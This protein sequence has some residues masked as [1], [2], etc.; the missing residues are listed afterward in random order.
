MALLP[1]LSTVARRHS[2]VPVL[3]AG[4]IGDGAT[5]AAV[6]AAGADGALL[7]T[8]FLATTEAVEVHDRS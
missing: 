7:G 1:L 4:G 8:A 3:A 5:L 2:D 6:L